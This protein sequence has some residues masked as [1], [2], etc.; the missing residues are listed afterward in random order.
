MSCR[1][2]QDRQVMV[3]S[4]D[5]TL[6]PGEWNDK[7]LQYSWLDNPSRNSMNRRA[8]ILKYLEISNKSYVRVLWTGMSLL[9]I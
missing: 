3:E 2:T 7:P 5:K 9:S 6:S 4:S 8:G 1:A